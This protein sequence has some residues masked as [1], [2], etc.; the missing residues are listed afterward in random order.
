LSSKVGISK[1]QVNQMKSNDSNGVEGIL[2][3]LV[4]GGGQA[5]LVMGYHL[6]QRGLRFRILDAS[7]E[8][9]EAWRRRWDSLRLFTPAQYDN[10]PG[11][12]FPA[13]KDSYPGKDDVADFLNTY[14][15]RF[16]LPVH[17]NSAVRW[18]TK[19]GDTYVAKT[20]DETFEAQ[21]VVVAT[22]PFQVPFTPSLAEKF[23]PD[24]VQLHSVDYRNPESVPE[25]RVL[26][27]GGANTG[28]QIALELSETHEV[29]ISVGQRLPTIPQRPLGRDVWWWGTKVGLTRVGVASRLGKRLSQRD[30]VI[31][32]G[33]KEL[34]RLGVK[35]QA[36]LVDASG[37][38][39]TFEGDDT[40]EVDAVL[41]A[42]GYR[43]DHSWIDLPDL[44]DERGVVKHERGV[45]ASPGLYLLGLSWQHTRTSALLGWVSEDAEILA[46]HVEALAQ[47]TR[48]SPQPVG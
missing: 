26:I 30:V 9:G 48:T 3:V 39:A 8:I 23:H 47:T 12:P 16:A 5:G 25:G 24:V 27:V 6:A 44:K 29:E 43:T 37:R 41:W 36:R 4:V 45:T 46:E 2:D 14:A 10:L 21:Q 13:S 18:L 32:G 22:G 34:R 20:D 19:V 33:M 11:M 1:E 38:I 28:C 42:T 35:V 17:M 15:E 7:A 31:G 40:T